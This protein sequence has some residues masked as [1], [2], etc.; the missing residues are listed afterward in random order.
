LKN[1]YSKFKCCMFCLCVWIVHGL[2]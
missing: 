1:K 2:H